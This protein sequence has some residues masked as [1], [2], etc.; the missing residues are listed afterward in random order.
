M[1]KVRT[2]SIGNK[3]TALVAVIMA[4]VMGVTGV[5]LYFLVTNNTNETISKNMVESANDKANYLSSELK[6]AKN[7]ATNLATNIVLQHLNEEQTMKLFT[8]F[9]TQ[10]NYVSIGIADLSG[11]VTFCDGSTENILNRAFYGKVADSHKAQISTPFTDSNFNK[12]VIMVGAPIIS[13]CDYLGEVIC[14]VNG[15]VV[16]NLINKIKVGTTGY[17]CIFDELGNY[18]VSNDTELVGKNIFNLI[19]DK[20]TELEDT[21]KFMLKGRNEYKLVNDNGVKTCFAYAPIKDAGWFIVIKAP[22]SEVFETAD[23]VTKISII[24]AT[25]A[26][27]IGVLLVLWFTKRSIKK[28][29]KEEANMLHELSL[30]HLNVRQKIKKRDEIGL[31]GESMNNLA[32]SLNNDVLSTLKKI[33]SGDMTLDLVAKDNGDMITPQ[34][35]T[36]V[37]TVNEITGE[38]EKIIESAKNGDL[39]KRIDTSSFEGSWG[40][41]A[42]DI[43][44]LIENVNNPI[45]DVRHVVE[46]MAVNDYAVSVD[47]DYN[48][49]F[50]DLADD[51]NNVRTRL[52]DVEDVMKKVSVGDMSRYDEF[53]EM[54][55]LSENDSMTPAVLSMMKNINELTVEVRTLAKESV[56]GNMFNSRG[57][58]DK[59]EGEYKEIINGFNN[60]LDAV[61]KPMLEIREVLSSMSVNDFSATISKDYQG[62]YLSMISSLDTVKENLIMM[63]NLAV[64]ISRGDISELEKFK[65]IGKRSENDKLTPAF[66][67][68]MESISKL[69]TEVTEIANSASLGKLDVHGNADDFEG[70]YVGIV[71]SINELVDAVAKPIGEIKNVM[72][73]IAD[74]DFDVKIDGEFNGEFG[75]LVEAVNKTAYDLK[76]IVSSITETMTKVS[77]GDLTIDHIESYD[78]DFA[79]ISQAVNLI[80]SSFNELIGNINTAAEKVEANS[81]E[82]SLESE[83]L[84]NGASTQASSIEELTSSIA[85]IAGQTSTNATDA[86]RASDLANSTKDEAMTGND[87]MKQMLDAINEISVSSHNISKIIKVIDDIAFQTKVLSINASVEAAHAGTYGKGFAVVASEVGSL[88]FKSANAVKDTTA[89]IEETIKRVESGTEIANNTAKAL[90]EIT[91]HAANVSKLL[92]GIAESS[93][94]QAT[95]IEQI[96]K[97]IELVSNIVQENSRTSQESA[98]ASK[99]LSNQSVKLKELIGS[100][101][102]KSLE[103]DVKDEAK[104]SNNDTLIIDGQI[105]ESAKNEV[106]KDNGSKGNKFEIELPEIKENV[107]VAKQTIKS[108]ISIPKKSLTIN[109]QKPMIKDETTISKPAEKDISISKEPKLIKK[110]PPI[111]KKII[112]EAAVQKLVAPQSFNDHKPNKYGI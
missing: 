100:F 50:K 11:N 95:G 29:L 42:D 99:E 70:E 38:T 75:D 48:G 67:N 22:R 76:N 63:Q 92:S 34:L 56:N 3:I 14:V 51:I 83:N 40:T 64:K 72:V 105:S 62:D 25:L 24:M 111:Q 7:S 78:G 87:Q 30:G 80:I 36:T 60:T 37:N 101:K 97:G 6:T 21:Y 93:N 8:E 44:D 33:A 28:P 53:K 2:K 9:K 104:V 69:I 91:E 77:E 32:E 52:L 12:Q 110:Q 79:A 98:N 1:K 59:F 86:T 45:S 109:R 94:N 103:S 90:N 82:L 55:V 41:L 39:S 74:A 65:E 47:G 20:D 10:S 61:T 66:T 31:I 16:E 49:L 112:D 89:L 71:N 15:S 5:V 68:M 27:V 84:S 85:E 23:N 96:D 107:N 58:A 35:I 13:G 57:N 19:S 81:K 43:N 108:D 17:A 73:S 18:V 106:S 88:A 4:V 26:I 46:R 54:G 102:L